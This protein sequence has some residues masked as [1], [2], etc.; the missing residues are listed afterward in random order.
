MDFDR[1]SPAW[2]Q[3]VREHAIRLIDYNAFSKFAGTPDSKPGHSFFTGRI[4]DDVPKARL[5]A[6]GALHYDQPVDSYLPLAHE[7]FLF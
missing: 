5:V 4:V 3:A 1:R 7:R 6:N 2:I